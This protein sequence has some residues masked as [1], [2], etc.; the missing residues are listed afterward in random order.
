M[1]VMGFSFRAAKIMK[2]GV[3][4]QSFPDICPLFS[5]LSFGAEAYFSRS[6]AGEAERETH[7]GGNTPRVTADYPKGYGGL[8]LGLSGTN[9]RV[10]ETW[11]WGAKKAAARFALRPPYVIFACLIL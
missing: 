1:P 11:P 4:A 3:F 7:A 10:T 5:F 6:L 8:T 9:P 2:R